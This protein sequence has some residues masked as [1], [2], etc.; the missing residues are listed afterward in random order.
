MGTLWQW[1][2]GSLLKKLWLLEEKNLTSMICLIFS[3][4]EMLK[5]KEKKK[6]KLKKYNKLKTWMSK[7][8]EM[9]N[10]STK[11]LKNITEYFHKECIPYI[12]IWI[13]FQFDYF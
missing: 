10:F 6:N 9:N 13:Y 4:G 12:Y 11:T 8:T 2:C 3:C 1:L 7:G 5:R